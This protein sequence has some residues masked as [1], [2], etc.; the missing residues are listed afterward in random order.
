MNLFPC[1][2]SAMFQYCPSKAAPWNPSQWCRKVD[3][4]KDDENS[5]TLFTTKTTLFLLPDHQSTVLWRRCS[6]LWGAALA[7]LSAELTHTLGSG[8]IFLIALS[9]LDKVNALHLIGVF[10]VCF[11]RLSYLMFFYSE[12]YVFVWGFFYIPLCQPQLLFLQAR[13]HILEIHTRD[14]NPK[15]SEPFVDEL[16]EKCVGKHKKKF[17]GSV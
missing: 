13:K 17:C 7:N 12:F 1:F 16:A 8:L 10:M 14:W 9:V 5:C 3:M 11:S 2:S 15:L 4:M 6:E